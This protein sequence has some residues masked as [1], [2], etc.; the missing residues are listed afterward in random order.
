MNTYQGT[1]PDGS[2][3]ELDSADDNS[4]WEAVIEQ[5]GSADGVELRAMEVPPQER[6]GP[7]SVAGMEPSGIEQAIFDDRRADALAEAGM[8]GGSAGFSPAEALADHTNVLAGALQKSSPFTG[9]YP[10][11]P[12]GEVYEDDTGRFSFKGDDGLT[13]LDAGQH[14]VLT[15][16][17]TGQ[18]NAYQ[19][20]AETEEDAM[21]P[22]RVFLSGI[23][24]GASPGATGRIASG[25]G[26][27]ARFAGSGAVN[28]ITDAQKLIAAFDRA[29]VDITAASVSQN[30]GLSTIHNFIKDTLMGGRIQRGDQAQLDAAAEAS[31]RL[32]HGVS[33]TTDKMLAG[34][35]VTKGANYFRDVVAPA[36]QTE[37]YDRA[38]DLIG[39]A[40]IGAAGE[41]PRTQAMLGSIENVPI[42][43]RVKE[44]GSDVNY[45]AL[46]ELLK[47]AT[48]DGYSFA[49]I[50]EI[51][52]LVRGLKPAQDAKV[53]S[54]KG[55]L[56]QLYKALTDDMHAAALELGGPSAVHAI[57]RA[58]QYTRALETTRLPSL[59]NIIG[60]KDAGGNITDP[61][62]ER[63]FDTIRALAGDK[64]RAGARQLIQ[65]RRSVSQAQW[66]DIT[67]A[68]IDDLGK[69]SAGSV[70]ST[71]EM[72]AP[73]EFVRNFG[74]LSD[75][76]KDILFSG[77]GRGELRKAIDDL[78]IVSKEM[79]RVQSFTNASGSGRYASIPIAMAT[80][81]V[82]PLAAFTMIA[83][84]GV[85]SR[86]L[87]NPNL[88]RWLTNTQRAKAA[89][90]PLT[91]GYLARRADFIAR[92]DAEMAEALKRFAMVEQSSLKQGPSAQD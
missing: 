18:I 75:R 33:E 68:I 58:D 36:R 23:A 53:G 87:S 90:N 91:M 35:G 49:S 20:G 62:G 48:K 64:G 1:A 25:L 86:L 32:S 8:A 76:G 19:R 82:E 6:P 67:G 72:F 28:P 46:V 40:S 37:L 77:P 50:R 41:L 9:V 43:A 34:E 45:K 5:F 24:A 42:A 31:R 54:Q 81:Y 69:P 14:A 78:L 11:G 27:P 38:D 12:L 3:F 63:V 80:A 29:K 65:I 26:G 83:G 39:S 10:G 70:K 21:G 61:A 13:P 88:V 51:R 52:T 92:N 79:K 55:V 85:A 16:P 71:D 84:S 47:S 89:R 60:K 56:K 30:R 4:A 57:K 66:D 44:F 17:Q 22:A 7:Q 74:A 2:Q 15:D 59:K 73:T